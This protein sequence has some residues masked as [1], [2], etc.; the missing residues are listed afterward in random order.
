M[1][2][3]ALCLLIL[4]S[5]L[6]PA[7]ARAQDTPLPI[8]SQAYP[9]D[10][11]FL[12]LRSGGNCNVARL[13]P[14]RAPQVRLLSRVISEAGERFDQYRYQVEYWLVDD[15]EAICGTPPPPGYLYA[16]VGALPLGYHF[17]NIGGSLAGVP[18]TAYGAAPAV[19]ATHAG[20]PADVSGLWYD[21][22]QTGRGVS[23]TRVE[24]ET[25]SLLWFT[26]D[27][28]GQPDWVASSAVES[29]SLPQA[30]GPGFNTR[31]TP[32]AP[33][34]ATLP[35]QPWG[36]LTFN[37]LGCGRAQLAWQ[38]DDPAVVD[39]SQ[40]LIKLAEAIEAVPCSVSNATVAIWLPPAP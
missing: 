40:P 27:G 32:L 12:P 17:F 38:A 3:A 20:F 36:T 19:V 31:G 26:H 34:A 9:G 16:D 2:A 35:M 33:G 4:F 14:A 21:P 8:P 29:G 30:T 1:R 24:P 6:F 22:T 15:P 28:Q 39:G 37:Y 23:V 13:D 18:L 10:H 5:T 11:L 25:L 7:A